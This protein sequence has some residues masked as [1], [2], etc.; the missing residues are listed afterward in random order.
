MFECVRVDRSRP[1]PCIGLID[2]MNIISANGQAAG[3]ETDTIRV[4]ITGRTVP[5]GWE[6]DDVADVVTD[7]LA[8]GSPGR[9][10]NRRI[11]NVGEDTVLDRVR[12]PS[13]VDIRVPRPVIMYIQVLE[14]VARAVRI[15]R[16]L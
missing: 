6:G 7:D 13:G 11:P 14:I 10:P 8:S 3:I 1:I 4:R 12:S 5:V 15:N 16:S 2:V 9:N